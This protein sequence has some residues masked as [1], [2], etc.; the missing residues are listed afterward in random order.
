MKIL[1][2]NG[3]VIDPSRAID[4]TLD[5]FIEK[6]KISEI[7]PKIDKKANKIIDAS[8][9]VIAPGFIDMHTHLRDPG[10][11]YK[12]TIY[13]GSL[14]AAKGGFTTIL[15]MPN[16]DPVNDNRGVT[17]YIISEAKNKAVV[18]IFPV[19][20]ISKKQESKE[21]SEMADL[22]DAGVIAFSDDGYS[23][24][25][26]QLMRC[27][28]DYSKPLDTLIIEHCEDKDLSKKGVMNEGYY[29]YL[30]GLKGIPNSSEE[31]IAARDII[32]AEESETKI[33]IAHV[34]T[35]GS[36]NLIKQAKN[37]KIRVTAEVTPHHLLLDDSL[38][39]NY[40]TNLKVNPPLRSKK[41][42]QKLINGIKDGT[43]DVFATD[44][45][46]HTFDDKDVEFDNAPFGI[47]GMETAVSLILDKFVNKNII[48]LKRFIE[49]F[50]TN[51]AN[52]LGLKN[53]GKIYEGADAD[54]TI[55]NLSK[56]IIV[57]K[58]KF[59]SKS[60]NSPFHNWKLRGTV[61]KTIVKGKVV[62]SSR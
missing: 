55:L 32:L 29:S 37:K 3:R 30:Y 49:M 21:L 2:K 31:V 1:V 35:K 47:N 25:N 58:N 4:E 41:D 53:K 36:V 15:C 59:K 6:G 20:S 46:P 14:A 40:D 33:H 5:I 23:V 10:Q 24:K 22:K 34:S 28:L 42:I 26:S 57:D 48:S 52:I 12:E 17:E 19:A 16:T 45:A 8:R 7:K 54:L 51:P 9:L 61:E 44:H 60:R 43:I 62:Y 13:T 56:E 38:L 39:S 18:N 11:E 50:S 27:A